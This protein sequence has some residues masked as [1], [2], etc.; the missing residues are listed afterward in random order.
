MSVKPKV[1]FILNSLP[2]PSQSSGELRSYNIIKLL[3][4]YWDIEILVYQ[5]E[6]KGQE[7]RKIIKKYNLYVSLKIH[8]GLNIKY[9]RLLIEN[10]YNGA[11]IFYYWIANKTIDAF[12]RSQSN[13][14]IIVDTVDLHYLRIETE[15]NYT[16]RKKISA[17]VSK[18]IEINN[19]KKA[20]DVV[21]VSREDLLAL[22]KVSG[23]GRKHLIPNIYDKVDRE[24]RVRSKEVVFIGSLN[25]YPNPDAIHWFVECIWPKV[26]NSIPEAR[27]KV[28]GSGENEKIKSL[29]GKM[30]VDIMGFVENTRDVINN[31]S[32]SVAPLRFGGGMKGKV[33]EALAHGIPVVSTKIGAQG[34]DAINGIHMYISDEPE[35]FA[36]YII[37]LLNDEN[38]QYEIG[39]N[40]QELNSRICSSTVVR[41][42]IRELVELKEIKDT[43]SKK[44]SKNTYNKALLKSLLMTAVVSRSIK[45]TYELRYPV[46]YVLNILIKEG[47]LTFIRKAGKYIGNRLK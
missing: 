44:S 31:C 40:G 32:V 4:D 27:F 37:K 34:F 35:E 30:N 5:E 6:S 19:Y 12:R 15:A 39:R 33:N 36:G 3:S 45:K 41:S 9:Y 46:K 2:D 23:I 47:P 38:M 24:K 18:Y 21:L 11:Y 20:T 8:L 17:F 43:D 42:K 16:R 14:F 28:V 7:I 26:L 10:S 1:L 25:W 13:S 22:Q 29:N